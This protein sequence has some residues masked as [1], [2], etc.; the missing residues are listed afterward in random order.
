MTVH[1]TL[2]LELVLAFASE[3][4]VWS[5]DTAGHCERLA[6][7]SEMTAL[8]MDIE[9]QAV[10]DIKLAAHLHDVGKVGIPD[11]ILRKPGPL[12]DGEWA[13]MREH[14]AIGARML[15]FAGLLPS[16]RVMVRAHHERF[17]GTGY[18]DGLRGRDIPLGARIVAVADAYDAMTSVRPY[19]AGLPKDEALGRLWQARG[20]QFDPDAVEAFA[21]VM[22]AVAVPSARVAAWGRGR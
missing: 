9:S 15:T 5:L 3:L 1:T 2:P 16:V 8:C 21:D 11:A 10:E 17:D 6:R 12:D 18:P 4:E 7:L 13:L 22:D 14:P 20:T 19:R